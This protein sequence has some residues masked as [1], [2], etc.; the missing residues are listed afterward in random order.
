MLLFY[1]ARLRLH[2]LP[3]VLILGVGSQ[4]WLSHRGSVR[5]R[6][7][8]NKTVGRVPARMTL[9]CPSA[10]NLIMGRYLA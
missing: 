3:P 2:R 6:P 5:A 4:Y 10:S 7:E 8:D 1:A 9:G